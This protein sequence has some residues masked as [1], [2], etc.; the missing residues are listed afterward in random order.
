MPQWTQAQQCA[1]KLRDHDILISAAAGSGKTATLTE[2]II[3][4]LTEIGPDGRHTGDISRMLVVTFTRAAAAELRSRISEALSA[5]I[6]AHPDDRYLYRQLV[7]LGSA[8]ICTI[9]SFYLEPVRAN[10]ERLGLPSAFRLADDTELFPLKERVL[11]RLIEDAYAAS[12]TSAPDPDAPLS[13]LAGNAFALAMDDL[14]PNRDRGDTAKLLLALYEKL[15]AFPEG[16]E[17]L[18]IGA[19]RLLKEAELPF[20]QSTEGRILIQALQEELNEYRTLLRDACDTLRRDEEASLRYLPSFAHDLDTV[21]QVLAELAAERYDAAGARLLAYAPIKLQSFPEAAEHIPDADTM[22]DIRSDITEA[23]RALPARYFAEP[24]AALQDQMRHTARTQLAL[25]R[26]LSSYESAIREEKCRR[27]VLDFSDVRRSLLKLLTDENGAPTDIARSLSDRFD[28]VYID[29][30]QDVDTVQDHIFATIGQ[31]GKRF[32]VGDIKQSIY[33]FRGAEPSIFTNYRKQFQTVTPDT[34][35]PEDRERGLCLFM[36][37]NFRCD[38]SIIDFTNTVCRHTFGVCQETLG[39]T[40]EDDLVMGKRTDA[41]PIPVHLALFEP[42]TR[43]RKQTA[44]PKDSTSL[45]PEA[46]YIADEIARLLREERRLNGASITASDIAVLMRS[47]NL[48]G[49]VTEALRAHGIRTTFAAADNLATD[50]TMRLLVNLLSVIDNPHDDVPLTGLFAAEDSPLS[51]GDLLALRREG[52]ASSLYDDLRAALEAAP[53]AVDPTTLE[54]L[55]AFVSHL[56]RWR[57]MATTLPIDRLLRK[58]F[59]EEPLSHLSKTPAYL[60][61]YDRARTFQSSAFCGL[62]QF[63]QHLRRLLDTP[64]A[65]SAAAFKAAEDAVTILTIHSSKGLQFPV[66]FLADCAALF[67][68]K[69]LSAT[70]MF[71]ATLGA[72]AK[73]YLPES[74]ELRETVTRRAIACRLEERLTEEEMR[75]LYVALTRA[76]ERLYLTAKLPGKAETLLQRAARNST[77]TRFSVLSCHRYLDWV[78]AALHG[79]PQ[80]ELASYYTLTIHSCEDFTHPHVSPTAFS[81]STVSDTPSSRP[82]EEYRAIVARHRENGNSAEDL[83]L[84][85]LPTKAAASKLRHAML[86]GVWLPEEFGEEQAPSLTTDPMSTLGAPDADR[87][88]RHRIELMRSEPPPF[89]ALL[90]TKG[91]DA[92]ERGT[93]THLFLQYCDLSRLDGSDVAL[94][95]EIDRLLRE[96]YLPARAAELLYLPHLHAFCQSE[97]FSLARHARRLWR[98]QHFDR[99]V[100]Y[101]ALT[102]HA[103]LADRLKD[104][105]LY[106]QGSIDLLLEDAQGELWLF[107]YKTDRLP[108]GGEDEVRALLLDRHADQLCIY[109]EA[110]AGLLGR[111]VDHICIY[112]LPLGRAVD[113]TADLPQTTF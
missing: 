11:D 84:H 37:E 104:Y 53:A 51:L 108:Q 9:D 44:L 56:T 23:L 33:A 30:Y 55:H 112:S 17:L 34:P 102:K 36:S 93:A 63:L 72:A 52:Y 28:A 95:R 16:V 74:A 81:S 18:H 27:G 50:P 6:A 91:A 1:M 103:E 87:Q 3:R 19:E 57:A 46:V 40:E 77:P 79:A 22:K 15:I 68:R 82:G 71:D 13:A 59:A 110:A 97:L 69:D 26:L 43:S 8:K 7:A 105:T 85:S 20:T 101:A 49:D 47:T 54:R 70:I 96:R 14:L 42:A 113:L 62:Y 31:G 60:A 24:T 2:R 106:V 86:D 111:R 4:S 109:A 5:A 64:G 61:L 75:L 67:N 88:I 83:L 41:E 99:F 35:L 39:Y 29:E 58:L 32:M 66:V 90:N 73:Q 48:A 21:E 45:S 94:K 38:R 10:F 65:L 92:A 98:E 89:E 12:A 25:Y 80:P 76:Q 78:L 100:P 107:D